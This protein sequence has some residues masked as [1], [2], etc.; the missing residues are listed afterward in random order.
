MPL[1]KTVVEHLA[2]LLCILEIQVSILGWRL[3]IMT[4]VSLFSQA[5]QKYGERALKIG[6]MKIS[7]IPLFLITVPFDIMQPT[8][9]QN[10]STY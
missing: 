6:Q 5:P 7:L 10:F 1:P 2:V 4:D 3:T 9:I 8:Q